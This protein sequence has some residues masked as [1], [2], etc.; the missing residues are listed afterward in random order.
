[1]QTV[2]YICVQNNRKIGKYE[3]SAC[4]N[5]TWPSF[6]THAINMEVNVYSNY[7]MFVGL[8]SF[9]M[10]YNANESDL[11]RNEMNKIQFVVLA[12][13]SLNTSIKG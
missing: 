1:M 8:V 2:L 7:I 10:S 12:I 5:F 4:N 13:N 9:D 3:S 11:V 6:L